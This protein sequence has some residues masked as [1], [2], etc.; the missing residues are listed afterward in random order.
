MVKRGS[1]STLP[2]FYNVVGKVRDAEVER[3]N[4]E[5]VYHQLVV[6]PRPVGLVNVA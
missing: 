4:E 5:N 6:L 2:P 3:G 1:G